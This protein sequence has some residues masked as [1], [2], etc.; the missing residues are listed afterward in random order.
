MAKDHRNI[1]SEGLEQ[2]GPAFGTNYART[3]LSIGNAGDALTTPNTIGL[4][5][6]DND[7]ENLDIDRES[8]RNLGAKDDDTDDF[9]EEAIDEDLDD[10]DD[11]DMDLEVDDDEEKTLDGGI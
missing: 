1:G 3:D 11:D 9:D 6:G 4:K 7:A 2:G 10:D 8:S 5:E